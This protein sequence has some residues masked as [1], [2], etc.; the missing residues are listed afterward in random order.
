MN[1]KCIDLWFEQI[2][3]NNS[4]KLTLSM[5]KI[6]VSIDC[7]VFGFDKDQKLKVLF[8][9]QGEGKSQYALP[10]DLIGEWEDLDAASSR[11]LTSL[12]FLQDLY[13]KQ[14]YV[15]GDPDRLHYQKDQEWL[16]SNRKQPKERVITVGYVSLVR[17]EDFTPKPSSFAFAVEWL[18]INDIPEL[19]FDHYKILSKALRFLKNEI[20]HEVTSELLPKKFTLSQLQILHEII[21]NQKL[22]KRNFRKN[23]TKE[24]VIKRTNEKQ[25]GVSHKPAQLYKFDK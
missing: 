15:F 7:V 20:D 24:G 22:D 25:K 11:I 3:K 17:M 16:K 14:F 9:K 1:D 8:I 10:G 19:A 5:S 23:I 18:D 13:L 21:L 12:T 2:Y 4:V 6:N